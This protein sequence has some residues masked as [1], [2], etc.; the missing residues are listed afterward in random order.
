MRTT[1]AS[2]SR[3]LRDSEEGLGLI[4]IVVSMFLIG[5][6]AIAF[7]PLVIRGLTLTSTNVTLASATQLVNAQIDLARAQVATSESCAGLTTF[8]AVAVAP[9]VDERGTSMQAA[10]TATCPTIYPGTATVTV[11]VTAGGAVVSRA[12]TLIYVRIP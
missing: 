2:R 7:L 8:V 12:Q 3:V 11:T 9:V 6:L 4:E 1:L 5:L 10:T